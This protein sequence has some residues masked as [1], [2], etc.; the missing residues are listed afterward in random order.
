MVLRR[1]G[2]LR[3][4]EGKLPAARSRGEGRK[5][6]TAGK[7][8]V[9]RLPQEEERR[10]TPEEEGEVLQ[11][12]GD[13]QVF[14][15]RTVLLRKVLERPVRGCKAVPCKVEGWP[16]TEF[17][18]ERRATDRGR[19]RVPLE[20]EHRRRVEEGTERREDRSRGVSNLA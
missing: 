13:K 4:R 15:L 14:L 10:R 1:L 18:E 2:V 9:G 16:R 6:C 3:A 12:L 8:V 5:G 20:E 7:A 11:L 17:A 19:R